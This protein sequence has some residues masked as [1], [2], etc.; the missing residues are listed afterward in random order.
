MSASGQIDY[1]FYDE[2]DDPHVATVTYFYTA[3]RPANTRYGHPDNYSPADPSEIDITEVAIDDKI[4]S[5]KEEKKFL[6]KYL[7]SIYEAIEEEENNVEHN[8]Y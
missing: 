3:G 7:D 2:N 5:D 8:N 6:E 4:L 1:E